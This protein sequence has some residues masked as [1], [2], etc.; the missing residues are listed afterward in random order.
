MVLIPS[1]LCK[2]ERFITFLGRT[3]E[4]WQCT[5]EQLQPA[6]HLFHSV[7][8]PFVTNAVSRVVVTERNQKV[9]SDIKRFRQRLKHVKI[10]SE[11]SHNKSANC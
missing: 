9:N 7:V 6:A 5:S 11:N 2:F 8:M 4:S 10:A 3:D 1:K